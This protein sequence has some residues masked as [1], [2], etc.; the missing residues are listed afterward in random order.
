MRKSL[1]ELNGGSCGGNGGR[2]GSMTGRGGGWLAKRLIV[3]N[4]GCG[5]GGSVVHS[6]R[7]LRRVLVGLLAKAVETQYELV[8]EPFGSL[9]VEISVGKV[10][11]RVED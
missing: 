2:G 10:E 8:V 4:E 9:W 5:G 11:K 7:S 3:S 6:G 1:F